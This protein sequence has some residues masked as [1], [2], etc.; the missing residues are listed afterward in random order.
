M[1]PLTPSEELSGGPDDAAGRLPVFVRFTDLVDANIVRNWPTLLR[2]IAENGFP[3]GVMLG[4][5]TRAWVLAEVEAWLATRP[6]AKKIVKTT[7]N[8][9]S[10]TRKKKAA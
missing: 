6:M 1:S 10:K 2:L 7:G 4:R 8:H 9:I 5:N 3:V